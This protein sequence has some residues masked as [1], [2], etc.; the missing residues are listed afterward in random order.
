M[1]NCAFAWSCCVLL[2]APGTLL[3]GIKLKAIRYP[4]SLTGVAG[5]RTGPQSAPLSQVI[6]F[7]FTGQPSLPAGIAEGLR[8][9]VDA[10]NTLGQP[11]NGLAFGAYQVRGN[12]VIFTPRLPTAPLTSSFTTTSDVAANTGLPGLL[13]NTTYRIEV[14]VGTANA[15]RNLTGIKNS[16]LLPQTFRTT[17]IPLEYFKNA[18]DRAPEV[19]RHQIRPKVGT[20]G[21]HPNAF[22]DPAGL[23]SSIKPN[24]RPPF[25]VVFKQPVSPSAANF[26]GGANGTWRLRAVINPSGVPEDLIVGSTS[27]LTTNTARGAEVLV[28]PSGFLPLG[29]TISLELSSH[30]ESLNG[31]SQPTQDEVTYSEIARYVVAADPRPGTAVDDLVLETFDTAMHQDSSTAASGDQL[32]SWDAADSNTLR[33]SFGFGGDGSLG[34]FAPPTVGN[35]VIVLDTDFQI[36]PLFSGATPDVRA[37]S[38]VQGGVFNF[39][40]FHLPANV[41]LTARGSNPLIITATGNVLI[42]GFIDLRGGDGADDQTFNSA[43]TALPG[44]SPS[45]G[46]GKGGD[47]HPVFSPPGAQSLRFI[48]TPQFGQSGFG[49]G[50]K[51]P[52][53]G[54]GGQCGCTLPFDALVLNCTNSGGTGVGSRGSGGGGGSY[55]TFIPEASGPEP[56]IPTSGRRGAIGAGDHLPVQFNAANPI[57]P[58]PAAYQALPGNPTNAVARQNDQMTFAEAYAAGLV[59]DLNGDMDTSLEWPQTRKVLMFGE[60]GPAV[61]LDEDQQNN[62][63][64][65]GGEL[66]QIIGGQGGGGGGSRTE[67]LTQDCK[68]QIFDLSGLP[69]TVLDARGGSGGG[70]GGAILIQAIGTIIMQG[71]FAQIMASGGKGGGGESTG[72]SSR[73]GGG[74]G[75][76]G[77]AIILQSADNVFISDGS[78]PPAGALD[79]SGGCG[80]AAATISSNP[81]LGLPGGDSATLQF[82]DGGPGGQGLVQIQIPDSAPIQVNQNYVVA[83]QNRNM[84]DMRCRND[85]REDIHPLV[86]MRRTPS[87]LT[88]R[89]TARSTWYDLGAV[90][91][92]FRP[93]I[94]TTAGSLDGPI[95]G[96]PGVGPFFRGTDPGTG[97]V[98]TD[99]LGNV[100]APFA[101]DIEVDAPDLQRADYI[102]NGTEF[103]F[104]QAV[105]VWFEGADEDPANPGSPDL[106]TTTEFVS[107]ITLL[108]GKRFLRWEIRFDIAAGASNSPTP[109]TPRQE[110]R[111]L[112]V[113]FKY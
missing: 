48:Q 46:S 4:A 35:L 18:G 67:G 49:P 81:G 71:P 97:A 93:P 99:S 29:H 100:I 101:N 72:T 39:T 36:F 32:A 5:P 3:G 45:A 2:C 15:V 55:A 92:D 56:L 103:P 26:E 84:F 24:R 52:G 57:P 16:V 107:D 94:V 9:R 37:G 12:S 14:Q 42:E 82:V 11:I 76:S 78:L 63:I 25:K 1:R 34:R 53:G 22:H 66:G 108:N 40:G 47:A 17:A 59:Y 68:Q 28:Y 86:P 75:G 70:G 74:G 31:T 61:F 89:S 27:V 44:G 38:V 95:F 19:R 43:I 69:F 80:K 88:P 33:A 58:P 85:T 112:R 30:F 54:G 10:T 60:A 111:R 13:P 83:R 109:N 65:A 51:G 110:V 41:T 23:F 91:S 87:P 20:S 113:P 96:V 8:I 6:V 21:I 102:P 79:V 90:T 98:R 77:G 64:G 104:S 50:N 105:E 73:G 62:F 106:S 7:Q